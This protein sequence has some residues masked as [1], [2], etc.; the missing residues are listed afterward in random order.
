MINYKL[1]WMYYLLF[2]LAAC[3]TLLNFDPNS[4]SSPNVVQ[5]KGAADNTAYQAVPLGSNQAVPPGFQGFYQPAPQAYY[6]Y[7]PYSS[8]VPYNYGQRQYVSYAVPFPAGHGQ[9]QY[10]RS[11]PGAN[12]VP[13]QEF[14]SDVSYLDPMHTVNARSRYHRGRAVFA[15]SR[16]VPGKPQ[17]GSQ[18]GHFPVFLPVPNPASEPKDFRQPKPHPPASYP[19]YAPLKA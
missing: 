12:Q 4:A 3:R 1:L 19:E 15:Q 13:Q 18:P 17:L 10:W 9:E 5:Y 7:S 14:F 11:P 6:G 16:Y 2:E 8:L